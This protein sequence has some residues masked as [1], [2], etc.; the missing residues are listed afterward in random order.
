MA[1]LL[2]GYRFSGGQLLPI[3]TRIA[4]LIEPRVAAEL[5]AEANAA[6]ER[7][8]I[9]ADRQMREQFPS[10]STPTG[11]ATSTALPASTRI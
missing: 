1:G 6:Q 7:Q 2:L 10:A 4:Q 8:A 3:A 9:Q 11:R 5:A